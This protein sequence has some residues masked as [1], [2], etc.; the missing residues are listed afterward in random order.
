M[1]VSYP[2]LPNAP[3]QEAIISLALGKGQ[4]HNE[5]SLE[6]VCK[7]LKK[8]YPKESPLLV[9]KVN[10]S[11][12]DEGMETSHQ[13]EK[14][15]YALSAENKTRFLR[16][17]RDSLTLNCLKPYVSWESFADKYKEAWGE[18][19][20]PL[21]EVSDISLI[22]IRY[23]NSFRIPT[24]N[25]EDY[26]L[27]A[28]K[29]ETTNKYD[30]TAAISTG[31]FFSRYLFISEK[32]MAQSGVLLTIR[33]LN[34]DSLEVIMDIEVAS[35]TTIKNYSGYHDITD[36][37]NRLRNFKNQIFFSNIPKAEELFK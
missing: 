2:N 30:D 16:M 25:W 28:P 9:N 12:N 36:V 3:I 22:S 26:I 34:K 17:S 10:F 7:V 15:G 31:D 6:S 13:K 23:I 5:S 11:F 8:S 20:K 19:I 4:K 32:Y 35:R 14:Q 27:M 18:Y 29:F 24:V 21:D 33:P 1:T 37:L